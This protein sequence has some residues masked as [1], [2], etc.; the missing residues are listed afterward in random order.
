MA[1]SRPGAVFAA[2]VLAGALLPLV[3][4]RPNRIAAGEGLR[5]W[6]ALP[7]PWGAGL[8]VFLVALACLGLG[9][10]SPMA[11]RLIGAALGL[12]I[13]LLALGMVAR[14]Q[15]SPDLPFLRVSPAAGFWLMATG[16]VFA[17]VDVLVRLK[18]SLRARAGVLAL[19]LG[20][21]ALLLGS[22]HFAG[23]AVMVEYQAR[24]PQFALVL[25]QHLMLAFGSLGLAVLIGV[26]LGIGLHLWRRG[27]G[28]V[29]AVLNI[30]QT[31]PSLAMFGLMIPLFGWIAAT[32]SVAASAGVSGIGP[33]PAMVA[34]VL[35][36]LLPVVANTWSGLAAAPE[37]LRDAARG[38]GM[39]R[40][41][42]L[43]QVEM[44]LALPL[45]LAAVRIVLVQ[46]IGLAVIAGLIGGGGLGVFVFQ[47]LSQ[48]ASDLILLG[49]LPAIAMALVAGLALD[50]LIEALSPAAKEE[51][52]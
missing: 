35:Y 8:A 31:I 50:L 51:T 17:L 13:M 6:E 38:M 9:A 45:L 27:Q 5:L 33:F 18:L 30:L 42:L 19:T 29:M 12:G 32:S 48:A 44:P 21:G 46:N 16:F 28:P 39:T 52:A 3:Q 23:L 36:A 41:Q 15:L 11:L 14:A 10:R 1:L 2:L 20:A 7:T 43:V 37:R 25:R 47:G 22:G 34:L 49:A 4:V 40:A 26:P 24:A